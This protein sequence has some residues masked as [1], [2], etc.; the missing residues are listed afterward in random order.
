MRV[1][2]CLPTL[3][4]QGTYLII[5][6]HAAVFWGKAFSRLQKTSAGAQKTITYGNI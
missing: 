3:T 6:A 1:F 4:G 5:R 2:L